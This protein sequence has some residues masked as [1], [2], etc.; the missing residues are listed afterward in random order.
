MQE[1]FHPVTK[2]TATVSDKAV[3]SWALRG[4]EPKN[5]PVDDPKP[6]TKVTK[7]SRPKANEPTS[8]ST[9]KEK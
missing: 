2:Q 6:S 1:I 8:Q 3:A 7:S 4:W 5:G 9:D